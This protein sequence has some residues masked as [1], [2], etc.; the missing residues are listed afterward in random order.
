VNHSRTNRKTLNRQIHFIEPL[1]K[2]KRP[3]PRL[4]RFRLVVL[5]CFLAISCIIYT[6]IHFSNQTN[7]Q[8]GDNGLVNPNSHKEPQTDSS[9]SNSEPVQKNKN[10]AKKSKDSPIN[11]DITSSS[12]ETDQ[13]TKTPEKNPALSESDTNRKEPSV[14]KSPDHNTIPAR[15]SRQK[16]SEDNQDNKHNQDNQDN[17]HNQNSFLQKLA[18]FF[19]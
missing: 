6:V 2:R 5:F 15:N 11:S 8:T 13:P 14:E 19:N 3:K 17:K 10:L 7:Y 4:I 9:N 18:K 12:S 16:P 1:P